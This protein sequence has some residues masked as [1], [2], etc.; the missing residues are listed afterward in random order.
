[1]GASLKRMFGAVA[2]AA[3]LAACA[4]GERLAISDAEF[5][6]PL[7]SSGIG[8]AY[9]TITSAVADRIVAVTSTEADS[10]EIHASVSKDGQASM[11]RME[12]VELPAGKAVRFEPGGMHLM[13]FSPR[14]DGLKTTFPITIELQSGLKQTVPFKKSEGGGEHHG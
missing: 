8:A 1:M 2:L 9:F 12:T 14:V 10:I 6:P 3:G 5:H 4:P 7:G 11:R 13:V